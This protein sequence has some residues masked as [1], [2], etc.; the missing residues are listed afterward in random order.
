MICFGFLH[1]WMP[2]GI[3]H[4]F[5]TSWGDMAESTSVSYVCRRCAKAKTIHLYGSGFIV[6]SDII[7]TTDKTNV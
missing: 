1:R 5:D 3:N 7:R 4:Y 2:V 6:L